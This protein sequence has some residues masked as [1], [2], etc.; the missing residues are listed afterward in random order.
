M[1]I[2]I[3]GCGSSFGVPSLARGW[4]ECD[5]K[6]PKNQRTRSSILAQQGETAVLFD[7]SPE[8]RTQLLHAGNPKIDALVYTHAHFDHMAG[9][10]DLLD[11]MIAQQR[12]LPVFLSAETNR[13]FKDGLNYLFQRSTGTPE[14]DCHVI[15]PYKSFSI[16]EIN[17]LP[18]LQ[19]HGNTRSLG[20]RMGD[21]AYSTDVGDMDKEGFAALAGIK[22]WVL[23]VLTTEPDQK[24]HVNVEKA[25]QWIDA[26]KPERAYF[27]HMGSHMDYDALCRTLPPHIRP[28]FDGMEIEV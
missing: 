14:F 24:K 1:K 11:C 13:Y 4:G 21:F 9:A 26:V 10:N 16:N 17:V 6:N 19:Y 7:T 22:I 8:L 12:V 27:T 18:I 25:L 3:L 28:V 5:P 23:G 2:T 15:V 20:F